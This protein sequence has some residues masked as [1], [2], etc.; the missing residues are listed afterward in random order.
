MM[1]KFMVILFGVLLI[2]MSVNGLFSKENKDG[3]PTLKEFFSENSWSWDDYKKYSVFL[4]FFYV[5]L[6]MI[7]VGSFIR[8]GNFQGIILYLSIAVIIYEGILLIVR[9]Q[10]TSSS[11]TLDDYIGKV[12][13]THL[14]IKVFECMEVLLLTGFLL[15]L[16]IKSVTAL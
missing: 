1:L 13:A 7:L 11:D 3:Y 10:T 6:Y 15:Q 9:V 12:T 4:E 2:K 14:P 16:I 5:L 8:V